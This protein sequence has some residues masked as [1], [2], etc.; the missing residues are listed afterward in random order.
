[1]LFNTYDLI[2]DSDDVE[3]SEWYYKWKWW[4][5]ETTVRTKELS[6]E[7]LISYKN[8]L[9]DKYKKRIIL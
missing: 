3:A 6:S 2:I 4:S 5:C 9:F 1:M 8:K 7:E